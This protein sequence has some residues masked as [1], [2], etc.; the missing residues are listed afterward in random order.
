VENS[1]EFETIF[2]TYG[3]FIPDLIRLARAQ[4]EN[5]CTFLSPL[6]FLLP[7]LYFCLTTLR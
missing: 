1:T 4:T 7:T 6:L 5:P 2:K 3:G